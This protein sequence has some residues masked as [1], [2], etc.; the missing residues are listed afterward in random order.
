MHFNLDVT[1]DAAHRL[2]GV[3]A[4]E[5]F[6]SHAAGCRHAMATATVESS[7]GTTWW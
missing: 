1:L 2:T 5:L 6:A 7:T 3:F 4:G